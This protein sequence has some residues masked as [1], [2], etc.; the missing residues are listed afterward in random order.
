MS[1]HK[2]EFLDKFGSDAHKAAI[3]DKVDHM[4]KSI[5]E[6]VDNPYKH[7][8]DSLAHSHLVKG[9]HLS[10]LVKHG[11]H[12]IRSLAAGN[13]NIKGDHL[14]HLIHHGQHHEIIQL[15]HKKNPHITG[16]HLHALLDK[17]DNA[18]RGAIGAIAY[19]HHHMMDDSHWKKIA[20]HS[21]DVTINAVNSMKMPMKHL[22]TAA[23]DHPDEYVRDRAKLQHFERAAKGE[24]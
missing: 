23:V 16:D 5:P 8:Y 20:T 3:P 9:E 11:D 22:L 15:L 14:D 24:K 6:F 2:L 18:G 7:G 10:H 13:P 4:V 12:Q 17:K 19:S 1:I 21:R